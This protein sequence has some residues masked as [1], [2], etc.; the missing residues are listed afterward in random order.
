MRATLI[1]QPTQKRKRPSTSI[2]KSDDSIASTQTCPPNQ[3][4]SGA[5]SRQ[6]RQQLLKEQPVKNNFIVSTIKKTAV[7]NHE[8][9][10]SELKV[11][12]CSSD[13]PYLTQYYI[14]PHY[15]APETRM[16]VREADCASDSDTH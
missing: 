15:E 3:S 1:A 9:Q 10:L 14:S 2:T 12:T 4:S 8:P 16:T 5:P 7:R 6:K 11:G 13:T